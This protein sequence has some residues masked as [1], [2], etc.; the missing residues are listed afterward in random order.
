[1]TARDIVINGVIGWAVI[2]TTLM[3]VWI[4]LMWH[5]GRGRRAGR[6]TLDVGT[7]QP[8]GGR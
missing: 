7:R 4:G 5:E 6:R 1:M 8:W 3:A 2:N